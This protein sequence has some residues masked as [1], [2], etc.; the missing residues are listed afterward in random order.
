MFAILR[1][2]LQVDMRRKQKTHRWDERSCGQ[3]F[4]IKGKVRP[5]AAVK[6]TCVEAYEKHDKTYEARCLVTLLGGGQW[7]IHTVVTKDLQ[8]IYTHESHRISPGK[9]SS[10]RHPVSC[11]PSS[12]LPAIEFPSRHRVSCP[13]SSFLPAIQFLPVIELLPAILPVILPANPKPLLLFAFDCACGGGARG[14]GSRKVESSASCCR[15]RCRQGGH[16]ALRRVLGRA[17]TAC[18]IKA[19][20]A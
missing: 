18:T 15:G 3:G 14:G 16:L 5:K 9:I 8:R 7:E 6:S 4:E 19:P 11:P 20:T 13:P 12:F 10:S 17:I 2:M 1:D